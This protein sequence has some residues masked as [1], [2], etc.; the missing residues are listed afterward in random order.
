MTCLCFEPPRHTT[1]TSH[2][3]KQQ[4]LTALSS[5]QLT[6]CRQAATRFGLGGRK[7]YRRPWKK[8]PRLPDRKR[9]KRSD[10]APRIRKTVHPD[11]MS[12]HS[13]GYGRWSSVAARFNPD[14]LSFLCFPILVSDSIFHAVRRWLCIPYGYFKFVRFILFLYPSRSSLRWFCPCRVNWSLRALGSYRF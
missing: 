10:Y 4:L 12:G 6:S 8:H 3:P 2:I 5:H 11:A 14:L 13:R 9:S 7:P 1:T